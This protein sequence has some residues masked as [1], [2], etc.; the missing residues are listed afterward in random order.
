VPQPLFSANWYR[1]KDLTPRLRAHAKI[2]RHNYRG[3][4]WYVLQ[5]AANDRFLR[6]T[7]TA[8]FVMGLMREGRSVDEVWRLAAEGLGDD[9]PTQD[10]LI[11]LL[12][13]LHSADVLQCDVPPDVAEIFERGQKH[14]RQ[15]W[16]R[17][18]LSPFAIRIPLIDPERFLRRTL[19]A[20][21]PLF[22]WIGGIAWLLVVLPAVF[23]VATHWSE[24]TENF[25]DRL[26]TPQSLLVIWMIFPVLK[27][28][29]ELGHGYAAKTFGGEVHDM[30][31]M[32]LVF[33]PV[34]YVDASC[35]WAFRSKYRRA[36]VG[37]GGMLVEMFI[38]ALAFY[39]W[40]AAEPGAV[41]AVAYNVLIVGGATTLLFNA[42][43]L[44]RFDGYYILSDLLEIPNLSQ[45]S[46]KYVGYLV[47]S[48]LLGN[49]EA[50]TPHTG[51]GEAP[52]MVAYSVSAFV[53]RIFVVVAIML[54]ILDQFF[55][56]GLLL[57]AFAAIGWF[58]IP[59]YR[60]CR[61]LFTSP[62]LRKHR[63]RA[64]AASGGA[65]GVVL[66]VLLL[67]PVPLRTR[68]EGVVWIPDEALVRAGTEGFVSRVAA[69][70]GV[71][72]ERGALL[73]ETRDPALEAEVKTLAAR[74]R[75]LEAR[76]AEE[77]TRDR[78]AQQMTAEEL[79]Y[80]RQG[81]ARAR[82]RSA[83]LAIHSGTSG[84]FVVPRS[85]DLPG[86]FVA[87]GEL[88]AYVVDLHTITVRAVVPQGDVDLVRQRTVDVEVRLAERLSETHSAVVK[89][90]VPAA[91]EELP[92]VAL[93]IGGGGAVPVDP[94]EPSGAR[95][96]QKMF[97]VEL[98]LPAR[99]PVVNSGGRVYVRFD[100]GNEPLAVQWYRRVRQLFLSRFH[101]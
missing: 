49:R 47:E 31:I 92:S 64:L 76:H 99:A 25:L 33:T 75:E 42:N 88:L 86:R 50:E 39:V 53:Y 13:Q 5:D 1:V 58:G 84:S 12:G 19:P 55:I 81:L 89:R 8:H 35:S 16:Q 23:L 83:E 57:G 38:A 78:V 44:L 93:G 32:L 56:A 77:R 65:L 94:T 9:A 72:V 70:P 61:H 36:L 54:W 62:R 82:E 100:H 85:D 7:P 45:R 4:I 51:P 71:R 48:R 60:A 34:P 79:L 97:E 40:L 41:R 52:R 98:A 74:V 15:Q 27:T 59:L 90:I 46:N 95:A 11:Q 43:P 37:A 21:R 10:E 66:G 18:L 96:V 63:P 73:I 6:F 3:E 80:A 101:V 29:H 22:G 91:S 14:E 28:F 69:Q 2:H 26:M 68:A 20:V 30:G 17:R 87:Q 67:I 24:L